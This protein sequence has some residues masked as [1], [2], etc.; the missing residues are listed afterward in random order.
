MDR[1]H[2]RPNNYHDR[3]SHHDR[4][5]GRPNNHHDRESHHGT[6]NDKY[7]DHHDQHVHHQDRDGYHDSNHGSHHGNDGKHSDHGSHHGYHGT[8]SDR[9]SY[10]HDSHDCYGNDHRVN[11]YGGVRNDQGDYKSKDVYI[12]QCKSRSHDRGNSDGVHVHHYYGVDKPDRPRETQRRDA[13]TTYPQEHHS[14]RS[15]SRNAPVRVTYYVRREDSRRSQTQTLDDGAPTDY[16]DFC[17]QET[18]VVSKPCTSKNDQSYVADV[19]Y[20]IPE[21]TQPQHDRVVERETGNQ[22]KT[23]QSPV[24]VVCHHHNHVLR[25]EDQN[26]LNQ[27][28]PTETS[29]SSSSLPAHQPVPNIPMDITA[30]LNIPAPPPSRCIEQPPANP[31]LPRASGPTATMQ[32][33]QRRKPVSYMI[34]MQKTL[35]TQCDP[36]RIDPPRVEPTCAPLRREPSFNTYQLQPQ[37]SNSY[38]NPCL[39]S[40]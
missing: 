25:V 2:G 33:T 8:H 31:R 22:P 23:C 19:T 39:R 24:A 27:Q 12:E 40:I 36:P 26:I 37:P 30:L 21:N 1:N 28:L 15:E 14:D 11:E 38:R 13:C 29:C 34:C 32:Q 10:G 9:G 18:P 4:N 5:H 17:H 16:P 3:E 7:G 35:E 20:H 6:Y